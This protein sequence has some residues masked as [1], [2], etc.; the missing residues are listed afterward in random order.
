MADTAYRAPESDFPR[1]T[2]GPSTR[3]STV[4]TTMQTLVCG[5]H[6]DRGVLAASRDNDVVRFRLG[7]RRYV[8]LAHP[9]HADHVFHRGRLNYVKSAEYE[10]IRQ[11]AGL[12]LLTDEGD[13]WATHRSRLN[14][15]FAKRRLDEI[16]ASMCVPIQAMTQDLL[17]RD[18][19]EGRVVIDIHES[20]VQMTLRVIAKALFNSD[21]GELIDQMHG[22]AT[23]GV[24]AASSLNRLGLVGALPPPVWAVLA[25]VAFAEKPPPPPLS[26]LHHVVS[27]LD[28]G[29]NAIVDERIAH[30]TQNVDLLNMMLDAQGEP[31]PRK[32]VRDEALTFLLAGHETTANSLSWFWYLMALHPDARARMLD[33]IDTV[34]A[35]RPIQA[36]DLA[37]LPWTTASLDEAQRYYPAASLLTR[38]AIVDDLIDGHRVRRGTNVV[39]PIYAIHHDE[40]FW[41]Q[42]EEFLPERFLPGGAKQHRSAYLPFGGGRR[43]CIGQTFALMEMVAVV[44]TMTQEFVF[45][46]E[47]GHPVEIEQSMTLRPKHGIR[48]VARRRTPRRQAAPSTANNDQRASGGAAR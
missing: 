3:L 10:P 43:R 32:R 30:P 12:N 25:K 39:I 5:L 8:A 24:R 36:D 21:F 14:P 42:P 35:G 45:D 31:W 4:R 46:L 26:V 47:P 38:T 6:P 27:G 11:A 13:S 40:R 34:L 1:P 2:A 20:M 23:T 44:A 16:F 29:V 28:R 22:L 18:R 7:T 9:D 33:E 41:D 15:L 19:D 17:A 48:V 37:S